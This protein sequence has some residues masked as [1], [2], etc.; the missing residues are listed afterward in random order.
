MKETRHEAISPVPIGLTQCK[1]MSSPLQ[2][3]TSTE[4]KESLT[5][6]NCISLITVTFLCFP[7]HKICLKSCSLSH[8]HLISWTHSY[9]AKSPVTSH[10]QIQ[11]PLFSLPP[12]W[13]LAVF[14]TVELSYLKHFLILTSVNTK[15]F[16]FSSNLI[17]H[18]FSTSFPSVLLSTRRRAP[19]PHLGS[20]LHLGDSL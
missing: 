4:E 10:C 2:E 7:S 20:F 9:L 13:L 12:S 1:A 3:R 5:H 14:D 19:E 11:G 18:F 16:W 8:G 17:S 15:L 6:K